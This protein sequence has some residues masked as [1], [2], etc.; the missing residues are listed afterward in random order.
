MCTCIMINNFGQFKVQSSKDDTESI[1]DI[2]FN[3]SNINYIQT[4]Y[5]KLSGSLIV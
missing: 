4:Y 1:N 3:P 2:Y 5:E